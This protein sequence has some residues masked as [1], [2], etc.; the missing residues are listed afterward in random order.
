MLVG[1][2]PLAP[3]ELGEPLDLRLFAGAVV[4]PVIQTLHLVPAIRGLVYVKRS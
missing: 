1:G 4:E 2:S 3:E